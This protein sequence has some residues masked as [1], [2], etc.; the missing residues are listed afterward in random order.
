[1][2]EDKS[3]VDEQNAGAA[4]E[5]DERQATASRARNRTVM[6]T[7]EMTGQVRALLHQDPSQYVEEESAEDPLEDF[8]PPLVDWDAQ[9]QDPAESAEVYQQ[10]APAADA[11]VQEEEAPAFD[12]M[13]MLAPPVKPEPPVQRELPP[14]TSRPQSRPAEPQVAAPAPTPPA[15]APRA[16]AKPAA[17]ASR[18]PQASFSVNPQAR[19]P[20]S[21]GGAQPVSTTGKTKIVAFLISFDSDENGEV[22]EIRS[23]R[24]LV[25]SRPT[26][27]GEFILI[28][29]ETISPLHAIVRATK[30]GTLQVLDQL[31]EFGT[32]VQKVGESEE[33]DVAGG[34]ESVSHGDVIRFGQR[35]FVVCLVPEMI[36]SGDDEE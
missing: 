12:P 13:T 16:A 5:G 22:Y 35:R 25:T 4:E 36:A 10:E 15:P 9:D 27:H 23:G 6:L 29:D 18:P 31:S 26:D 28:H 30:D 20:R 33:I 11:F 21:A 32:G 2:N 19:A 24:W 3:L 14:M 7:P 1:M 34:L 8:L 17:P